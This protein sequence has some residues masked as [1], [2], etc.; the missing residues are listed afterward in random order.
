MP[1]EASEECWPSKQASITRQ[2]ESG[3]LALFSSLLCLLDSSSHKKL[4][5]G[6]TGHWERGWLASREMCASI[7]SYHPGRRTRS[8]YALPHLPTYIHIT[9]QP[10]S[11]RLPKSRRSN[12]PRRISILCY[13]SNPYTPLPT[14]TDTPL[15][16]KPLS[17]ETTETTVLTCHPSSQIE[18]QKIKTHTHYKSVFRYASVLP[19][20]PRKHKQ[21]I[22]NKNR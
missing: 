13:H 2:T 15:T 17:S 22:Q 9:R 19:V 18:P 10:G 20:N 3:S 8:R 11:N 16:R 1:R 14:C 6:G 12:Y 4:R 5:K 21:R 7:V